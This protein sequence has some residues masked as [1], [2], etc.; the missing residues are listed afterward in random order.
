V[1]QIGLNGGTPEAI[2]GFDTSTSQLTVALAR[3]DDVIAEREAGPDD[4][5]RPR[6]AT[7]LLPAVE[8][9]IAAGD[10]WEGVT[11]IAVGLG[12]GTFTGLRIGVS[13]ARALAQARGV[14]LSGVSSLAALAA[15]ADADL[16][17]ARPRLAV[18]DAKRGEA[19]AAL[20]DVAG[21]ELWP[22]WVGP[23]D[24]LADRVTALEAEP[25]AVGEGS[26]RFREQLE[27]AGALVP[28]DGHPAH[29]LRAR[30]I[31]RLADAASDGRDIE[32]NYLRRPDAEL[33]RERDHGPKNG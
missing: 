14:G 18:L 24:A 20:Y 9:V 31:C 27:A 11:R 29:R 1:G 26:V 2:L 30:H 22:A 3:G 6:H 16:Q 19:F 23:P 17:P 7:A 32:P 25:L 4:H 28:A 33:W 13:T 21:P 15:G 12:P 10:G 8:A 5:G